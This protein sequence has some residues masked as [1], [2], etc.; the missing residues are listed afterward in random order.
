MHGPSVLVGYKEPNNPDAAG[1]TTMVQLPSGAYV[2]PGEQIR[3]HDLVPPN[4]SN[5]PPLAT[6]VGGQHYKKLKIQPVEYVH[7]NNLGY[8]EG[9]VIKYVS[10]WRDKGGIDDLKKA[11]HFIE[12][13]I[14]L[15][16]KKD[17]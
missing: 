4:W 15:E 17:V 8:F 5:A 9:R 2:R 10:R 11:I 12:L 13:L 1:Q 14:E 3:E 7:A 16:A 6:Q